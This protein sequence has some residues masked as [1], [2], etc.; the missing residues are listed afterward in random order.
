MITTQISESQEQKKLDGQFNLQK[1]FREDVKDESY[2]EFCAGQLLYYP[3][4]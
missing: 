2:P 1:D 4:H 3:F